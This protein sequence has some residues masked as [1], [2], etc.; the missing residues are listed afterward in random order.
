MIR[1][2]CTSCQKPL[3][4]DETKLPMKEVAFPCPSCKTK[5]TLD[6]RKFAAEGA[7]AEAA[8][9]A[10]TLTAS[11]VGADSIPEDEDDSG[12]AHRALIVGVDS[13]A[14]REAA[15]QLNA[16]PVYFA[17]VDA[18]REYYLREYPAIVFLNPAQLAPPPL[19]DLAPIVS[20]APADRRKGF[21]ILVADGLRTLDG[22]AAFLYGVN[23]VMATKDLPQIARI[24]RDAEHAHKKLYQAMTALRG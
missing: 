16:H 21:F 6:R 18:A 14:V 17:A 24:Y 3:S 2:T 8:A 12:M 19:T 13:P 9:P 5:L 15:K 4:I 23:M 20:V 7:V 10:P 11:S 22:N 1:I